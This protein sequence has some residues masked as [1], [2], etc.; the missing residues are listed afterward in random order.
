MPFTPLAPQEFIERAK[1]DKL[2]FLDELNAW[3][4]AVKCE[5]AEATRQYYLVYLKDKTDERLA[6]L[7]SEKRILI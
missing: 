6:F 3:M 1:T 7:R 2:A 4:L 5:A